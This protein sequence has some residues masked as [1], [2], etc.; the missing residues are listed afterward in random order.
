MAVLDVAVDDGDFVHPISGWRQART[1]DRTPSACLCRFQTEVAAHAC[2]TMLTR[3]EIDYVVCDWDDDFVTGFKDS[4]G[5]LVSVK[6]R[7]YR[8]VSLERR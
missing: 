2:L 7:Q 3:V 8:L 5:D 1:A 4:G 6:H